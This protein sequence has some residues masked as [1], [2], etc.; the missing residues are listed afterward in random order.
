MSSPTIS[1][2][3]RHLT[4]DFV[5]TH[6]YPVLNW[7]EFE[8]IVEY[9]IA[10][11]D[12][13]SIESNYSDVLPSLAYI[14]I[15]GDMET[16][17]PLSAAWMFY[18]L[19]ARV[20]DDIQDQDAPNKPWT[21]DGLGKSIPVG[22]A[23]INIP[24]I[25]LSYL[26][27]DIDTYKEISSGFGRTGALAA[28]IQS[29]PTKTYASPQ[30][31]EQYFTHVIATTVEIFAA[32][33]WAGGRLG[34][35][36]SNTLQALR[37]FGYG[38]GMKTAIVLD[39]RDLKPNSPGKPSDLTVGSYKL[40]V[41]YAVSTLT[42]HPDYDLLMEG[43]QQGNLT[44]ERLKKIVAILENMGAITWSLQVALEFQDKAHRAL[45][46]LSSQARKVLV[47]YVR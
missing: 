35:T 23:L 28:K 9:W 30:S 42:D 31:L 44:G 34:T 47:N 11:R 2:L 26:K 16:S 21:Q 12:N 36:D 25:C 8:S 41:L 20:L 24:N 27:T 43:L 37:E 29:F 18:I 45:E 10:G 17:I 46:S 7:N 14:A 5:R 19:G 33:A 6:I 32:G 22:T 3:L 1:D 38:L 39:C 4:Y 40:P 15:G 13:A